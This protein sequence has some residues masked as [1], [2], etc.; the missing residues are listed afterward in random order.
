MHCLFG[1]RNL[2][3]YLILVMVVDQF[4][5]YPHMRCLVRL[6]GVQRHNEVCDAF[7][8]LVALVWNCAERG[9]LYKLVIS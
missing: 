1:I 2:F 4:F 6:K 5:I 3:I 7:G 8:D 9:K